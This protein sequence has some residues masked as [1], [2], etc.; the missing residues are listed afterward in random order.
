MQLLDNHLLLS[1][2]DL[3]NFLECERLTALDLEV[4]NGG[5]GA[6]PKRV[7]T[8]DL[9]AA[10]GDEHELRHL[11]E[12]QQV[13]GDALV[14]IHTGPRHA[15]LVLAAGETRQAMEVGAPV[16]Y[17]ATFLSDGW[18]GHVDF[19]ERVDL[20]SGLGDWSYEVV[21]TKLARSV[22]PYFVIQLCLYSALVA[23]IQ[24]GEPAQ[25]HVI[26]GTGER[27][28]LS[29]A[30]FAAY[31]RRMKSHFT[32]RLDHGLGDTYPLP[33]SHCGLCRWSDVC[34][35]RREAD[36]HLSLVARLSRPQAAKLEA[37]GIPTVAELGAAGPERRPRGMGEQTF[38]RL[39]QQARLQVT[40]RESGIPSYELLEPELDPDMPRRGLALVPRPSEGDIFFDIEGDPF[41]DDGLEYLWGVTYLEDGEPSFRAFWGRDR[42]EEGKAFEAFIDFV[43]ARR[44]RFP[45]LHVY[46]YAPY[47][48]TAMKRMMGLHATRE[49]EVDELLREHVLVDLYRVVEQS[50]RISQPSYSIKKV[51]AFYMTAREESVTDGEDSI[52]IFEQWLDTRDHSLLDAIEEYNKVDCDSTLMLRDWLLERRAESEAQFGIEIPWLPVGADISAPE[53]ASADEQTTALVAALT[54]RLPDESEITD[55]DERSRWLLAQLLDYHRR[56]DK[57]MWWEYFAR[58]EKTPQ[59]LIEEDSEAMGG[60]APVGEPEPLPPPKRSLRYRLKYPAQEHKIRPGEFVDPSS[61]PVDP[62]TGELD[63]FAVRGYT[64]ERVLD[65]DGIIEIVRGNAKSAEPLPV[66]LIPFEHYGADLQKQA[67]RE[68]AGDVLDRGLE[69]AGPL[70]AARSILRRELPR[71]T[72]LADGGDLQLGRHDLTRTTAIALGLDG[73]HLFVQG[74]PG[75]GK[76]YTGAQ[77]IL[78]LLAADNRV[79]ISANSHKAICNLLAEI[80]KCN[81]ERGVQ[82]RGLQKYSERD[83]AFESKLA[84]P[85]I[86]TSDSARDFPTAEG[87]ELMAGTAW[88][89]CREEMRA[90]VDYLV[91]DEAGQVSL[92]D[93]LA[94][95]SAARNLILLGDPL[96]LAQVSTG[97]HPPGAG[98]SVLEHLLG[99]H[100]TIPGDRGVFLDQTRRMHPDVCRFVSEAVYDGRLDSIEECANQGIDAEG[101]ITG[102]GVRSIAL[103]HERNTRQSPE[104]ARRITAEVTGLIGARYTQSDLTDTPLRQR[105]VIVV[106]PYNAQV[107]CL[108][109]HLDAAG[110][111]DVPVGTVDKFQGQEAAIAFFS[112]ATSSGQDVPRNVEFLY[113]RNRLNVAVSRARCIAV[114]V[115]NPQLMTIRC[116]TVEQMRLVNAL[117]LL[118]EIAAGHVSPMTRTMRS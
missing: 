54:E 116:R 101:E 117:C 20:P 106:S 76:T 45:D 40:Q 44:R 118:D 108:R 111:S 81:A 58:L 87:I 68:L 21:D 11:A 19:L 48:P 70:S 109:E 49:D 35:A 26:L 56:E 88:L 113:S 57:P 43:V 55:A 107:R 18:R 98:S 86:E 92:A 17:Q 52:L 95:S 90:S 9:V 37:S 99:G 6:K 79:G 93:A 96:Q 83:Q 91:I 74:P 78:S 69:P 75:S 115:A 42:A 28:S 33:V 94:L 97:S 8:A 36:D 23:E 4:A 5:L 10:K 67:L 114:L 50:L 14:Q 31:Y 71:S 104:E 77:L 62:E 105:D 27:R 25:M 39:R 72:A 38:E 85:S 46:H 51:E 59:Q 7:D 73:S 61:A 53:I 30:D 102:T 112:M 13:H 1:A 16:I 80:E 110:L 32:R 12:L 15:D 29:L 63:P 2:S 24:G 41:Y 47:E 84:E 65:D 22:K 103:D 64:V 100:S 89:W 34:D 3:I 60:L 66:A 82:F